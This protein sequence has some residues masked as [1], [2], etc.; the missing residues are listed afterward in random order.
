MPFETKH[1]KNTMISNPS[2]CLNVL[3]DIFNAC[4]HSSTVS[5][6]AILWHILTRCDTIQT[7]CS[8]A[9][10][11]ALETAWLMHVDTF[12]TFRQ[13]LLVPNTFPGARIVENDLSKLLDTFWHHLK[14]NNNGC[15]FW[16]VSV[17]SC[18]DF[19]D[20]GMTV[21]NCKVHG[22]TSPEFILNPSLQNEKLKAQRMTSGSAPIDGHPKS[23]PRSC[24][25]HHMLQIEDAKQTCTRT[26]SPAKQNI[27]VAWL[28]RIGQRT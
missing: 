23:A 12:D 25:S 1:I 26:K 20:A 13:N 14:P 2:P 9:C 5:T 8:L 11:H 16:C 6:G 27:Q 7:H 22:F 3:V 18:V 17:C 4:W 24:R 28:A 19:T 21:R 10:S 15:V